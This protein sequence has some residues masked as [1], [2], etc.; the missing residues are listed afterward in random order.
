ML[1]LEFVVLATINLSLVALIVRKWGLASA[2]GLCM[3]YVFMAV[4]TDHLELLFDYLVRPGNLIL[5]VHEFEFRIYPT[6]VHIVG[7]LA[8]IAG[9]FIFAARPRSVALELSE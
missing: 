3:V 4:V 1:V 8:L 5:G 2:E 7:L 6:V 9:L